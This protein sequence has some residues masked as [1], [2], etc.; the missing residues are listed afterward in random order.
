M[1]TFHGGSTPLMFCFQGKSAS[2]KIIAMQGRT[3]VYFHIPCSG[4]RRHGAMKSVS[5]V[6]CPGGEEGF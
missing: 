6:G 4:F 3:K 2:R 5:P 1:E